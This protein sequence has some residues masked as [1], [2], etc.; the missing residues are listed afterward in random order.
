ME[1]LIILATCHKLGSNTL[2]FCV[3]GLQNAVSRCTFSNGNI[4]VACAWK[5]EFSIFSG[6]SELGASS[7]SFWIKRGKWDLKNIIIKLLL[8]IS[9]LVGMYCIIII[10]HSNTI[11]LARMF[12]CFR[13]SATTKRWEMSSW[14]WKTYANKTSQH[15]EDWYKP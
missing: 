1:Q 14:S 8:F 11:K 10:L 12:Q 13:H 5:E 3:K 15:S 7:I 4:Q 2:V 6:S 9:W